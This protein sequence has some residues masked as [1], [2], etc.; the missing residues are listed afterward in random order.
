MK[1]LDVAFS[2]VSLAWCRARYAE[3]WR[4]LVQNLWTGGYAGN[5]GLRAVARNN[6]AN[7]KGAGL[8]I[9]GYANAS[10]PDWWPIDVQMREIRR[11]AG[12]MWPHLEHVSID[13]EIP[14]VTLARTL[15]LA[16][17]IIAAGQRADILYTARW[18]WTGHMSNSKD[19]RWRRFK[20]WNADYDGD[21][22]IDF[23]SAPY[24]PWMMADV[25]G[26]QYQGTTQL[27]G[28]AVDLN[29]FSETFITE[30]E[31]EMDIAALTA[32][33]Y[34]IQKKLNDPTRGP[35]SAEQ[36]AFYERFQGLFALAHQDMLK[37]PS[38]GQRDGLSAAVGHPHPA[39]TV[40]GVT[41]E[42]V[43]DE[44]DAATLKASR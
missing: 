15:E 3:G 23:G 7:A 17:A 2:A 36:Q 33:L 11:N 43:R 16:D 1:G 6:L 8:R 22:D 32:Y 13:V 19:A 20:L 5:D 10:P 25:V 37:A 27:A 12:D 30:Q 38:K 4:V 18:F 44:I 21:P 35:L 24:G 29:T 14:G 28:A 40:E 31:D 42:Q 34:D 39:A 9:A 41:L 26:G